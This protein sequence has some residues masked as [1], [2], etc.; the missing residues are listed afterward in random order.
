[1]LTDEDK[2]PNR[3]HLGARNKEGRYAG[4]QGASQVETHSMHLSDEVR[5]FYFVLRSSY[6]YSY[7]P[8]GRISYLSVPSTIPC[9]Y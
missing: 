6:K 7:L 3:E 1:M 2:G 9:T 4:S 5:L 8:H